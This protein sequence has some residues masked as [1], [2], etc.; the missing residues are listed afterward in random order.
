M[1]AYVKIERRGDMVRAYLSADGREFIQ[2]GEAEFVNLKDE[3]L[4]GVAASSKNTLGY[5]ESAF[6]HVSLIKK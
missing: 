3:V 6:G 1:G 2:I 5:N 4:I